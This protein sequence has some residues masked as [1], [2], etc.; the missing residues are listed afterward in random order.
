VSQIDVSVMTIPGC[1]HLAEAVRD[2]QQALDHLGI[3]SDEIHVIVVETADQAD[4]QGF[5]GSPTFLV[6][7]SDLFPDPARR[8]ALSCRLYDT[9]AGLRG[10]PGVDQLV[11]QLEARA[12]R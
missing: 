12:G 3:A 10:S 4:E 9:T 7:G 11:T 6:D 8:A 1:P 2:I 5:L